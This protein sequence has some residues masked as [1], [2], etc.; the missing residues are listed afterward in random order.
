[1]S[2][3]GNVTIDRSGTDAWVVRLGAWGG[4]VGSL[5]AMV[6]NLLHPA[7]PTDDPAGVA[8]TISESGIWVPVHLVIVVGLILMLGGLVAISGSIQGG[9][10][11]AL[12]QLGLVAAAAGVAVGVILVIVDGVAAKHLADS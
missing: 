4:I 9:I 2:V 1:M 11:G 7:P 8:T 12:A 3:D 5:L 10:A 6:G